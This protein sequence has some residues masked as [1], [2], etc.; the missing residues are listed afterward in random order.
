MSRTSLPSFF[1]IQTAPPP[2]THA[3]HMGIVALAEWH[4]GNGMA[5]TGWG[6]DV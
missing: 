6:L 3:C 4:T 2:A 5:L 1:L